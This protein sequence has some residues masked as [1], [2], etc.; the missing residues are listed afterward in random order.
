VSYG[1]GTAYAFSAAGTASQVLLS[2]GSGVPTWA[3]QSS[4]S[5][6]SA[7]SATSATTATNLAG[8]AASRIPYQT[9][10]GTTAF[11]ANGT[12]GQVLVSAG[13]SVPAWGG[14]DGGTF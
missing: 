3:D 8:G 4:L 6:G 9:G 10:A 2:G 7:T 12:A 13:A 11:I 14:I 1:T 5:V